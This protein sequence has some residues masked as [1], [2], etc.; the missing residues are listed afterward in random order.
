MEVKDIVCSLRF[1]KALKKLGVELAPSVF[2]FP[3][4]T[5]VEKRFSDSPM[6]FSALIN[7]FGESL[8]NKENKQLFISTFTAEELLKILPKEIKHN[9]NDHSSYY[10]CMGYSSVDNI[11]VVWYEDND[12]F[13]PDETLVSKSDEMLVNAL[14]KLLIWLLK[15]EKITLEEKKVPEKKKK[16]SKNGIPEERIVFTR[17]PQRFYS[18]VHKCWVIKKE[19]IID[20]NWYDCD[21]VNESTGEI[22]ETVSET[23]RARLGTRLLSYVNNP[24]MF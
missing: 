10:L 14:A 15:N 12:L 4:K 8:N 22:I 20:G 6:L 23:T 7:E 13:G 1:S 11:P 19:I 16:K 21:L 9:H 18:F 24:K 3:K 17:V 2:V 5:G